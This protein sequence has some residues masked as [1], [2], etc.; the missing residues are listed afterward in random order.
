[1]EAICKVGDGPG[2]ELLEVPIPRCKEGEVLIEVEEAAICASD[3]QLFHW[4]PSVQGQTFPYPLVMGHEYVGWVRE[5]GSGVAGFAPGDYVAGETHIPCLACH[6]C[7]T[8]RMHICANLGIV[9]RTHDGCFARYLAVSPWAVR[10][11]PARLP[12]AVLLE[13]LGVAIHA[14]QQAGVQEKAVV[15]LGCGPI[16][17]MAAAAAKRLGALQVI[18]ISRTP[19]KLARAASLG[20]DITI[21]SQQQDPVEA[22]WDATWGLGADVVLEMSG[23]RTAFKQGLGMLRKQGAMVAVGNLDGPV[24]IDVLQD[25]VLQEKRLM[26]IFGRCMWQTWDT[27][28][29]LVRQGDL[30]LTSFISDVY[31]LQ[32]FQAAFAQAAGSMS[33]ILLRP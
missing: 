16:G 33:K 29:A 1:M 4:R 13:P 2:A 32:E 20:A 5:V 23:S 24:E 18:A 9:G 19:A 30:D 22:V 28:V 10:K 26:G 3:L 27:A 25:I 21:N 6:Y 11:I 12:G 7:D 14:I 15:N 17:L 31:P 8:G